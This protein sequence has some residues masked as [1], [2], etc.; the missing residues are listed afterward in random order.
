MHPDVPYFDHPTLKEITPEQLVV[1][2]DL[3]KT[4]PAGDII[5]IVKFEKIFRR[6]FKQVY[7]TSAPKGATNVSYYYFVHFIK[8][9]TNWLSSAKQQPLENFC[10]ELFTSI[11]PC[12][13]NT[14]R[15][16]FVWVLRRIV[17]MLE[18]VDTLKPKL[19]V[20]NKNSL[21][22][23]RGMAGLLYLIYPLL[24]INYL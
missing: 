9:V 3:V 11:D 15:D 18:Y 16:S 24:P 19:W 21:S 10:R 7:E 17:L 12:T 14:D 8:T 1:L 2:L 5:S 13:Y 20:E 6:F 23:L 22:I 4:T